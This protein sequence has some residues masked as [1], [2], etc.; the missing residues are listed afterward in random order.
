MGK[1]YLLLGKEELIDSEFK[2]EEKKMV[3][4]TTPRRGIPPRSPRKT[5]RTPKKNIKIPETLDS[6][7]FSSISNSKADLHSFDDS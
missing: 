2:F 7:R 6:T 3:K 4:N 1:I 5:S